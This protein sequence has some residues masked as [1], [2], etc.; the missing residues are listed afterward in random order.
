MVDV[1]HT[2][3]GLLGADISTGSVDFWPNGGVHQPGCSSGIEAICDHARSWKYF[4][5]SV[6]SEDLKFDSIECD[7]YDGFKRRNCSYKNEFNNMGIDASP[8]Y[9]SVLTYFP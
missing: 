7:D 9:L 8:M 6:A 5:E 3:A 2:D 1:I 4:A